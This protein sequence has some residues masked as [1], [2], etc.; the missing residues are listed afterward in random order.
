MQTQNTNNSILPPALSD[1]E[2]ISLCWKYEFIS[3]VAPHKGYRQSV[4]NVALH[5]AGKKEK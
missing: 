3:D 5:T 4:I 1:V 2:E